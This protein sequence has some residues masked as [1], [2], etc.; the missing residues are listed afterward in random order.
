[1]NNKK[2]SPWVYVGIGC[3]VIVVLGIA[4]FAALGF[5]GY[6][7]AKQLEADMKDPKARAAKTMEVLG[8][9]RLPDGYHPMVSV[10]IP[11]VMDMAM[12]SDEEPD[13]DGRVRRFGRRGF[14]YFQFLNPR[15]DEQELRDYFEGKTNDDAVLRRNGINIHVRSKEFIRRGVLPMKG[16]T[17]MYLAQRGGLDL[18]E[19][20]TDGVN[21]LMLI[22][23]PEDERMRM[24]IWF[25]P[26]PDPEAPLT[27]ANF[28]GSPADEEALKAFMEH[29]AFCR[30]SSPARGTP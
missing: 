12:L 30:K 9:E 11:F 2:T 6:R 21:V 28:A 17:L 18:T 14:L 5:F 3:V 13:E 20:R 24:A 27:K 23:C 15:S 7:W 10:S 4:A 22:D 25:G 26:D 29:F 19:G 8:C 1:M 16:Y